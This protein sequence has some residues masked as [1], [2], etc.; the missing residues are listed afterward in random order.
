M[1]LPGKPA[2]VSCG[3]GGAILRSR[4]T[5]SPDIDRPVFN[6]ETIFGGAIR[7]L[8]GAPKSQTLIVWSH[9]PET[10]LVPSGEIANV[11][12]FQL[13]AFVFLLTSPSLSARQASRRQFW[14][15]RRDFKGSG[16]PASQTLIFWSHDPDRILAP[17]GEKATEI[18][19]LSLVVSA[20]MLTSIA[21][22]LRTREKKRRA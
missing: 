4:R 5:K 21:I 1:W 13:W 18:I 6:P 17:S 19:A 22:I 7:G 20:R 11:V 3:L 9:D 10:I 12:M 14:P 8:R 16:A 15:R 2:G